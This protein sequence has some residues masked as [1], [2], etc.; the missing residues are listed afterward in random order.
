MTRAAG[1]ILR[2]EVK[3]DQD[4]RPYPGIVARCAEVLDRIGMRERTIFMSFQ[5]LSVA[6]ASALGGFLGTVLLLEAKPWRGMGPDGALTLSCACGAT[7]LGLPISE[8]DPGSVAAIR[9]GSVGVSAWGTND[10]ATIRQGYDLGLDVIAT[11]DPPLALRLRG[12]P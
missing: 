2:L 6:E 11:D 10:A 8:W 1:R 7:E 3:A 12:A 5:P 4:G 9:A